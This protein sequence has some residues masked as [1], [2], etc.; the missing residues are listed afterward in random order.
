MNTPGYIVTGSGTINLFWEGKQYVVDKSHTNYDKVKDALR[1]KVYDNLEALVNVPKSVQNFGKKDGSTTLEVRDGTVFYMGEQVH[2]VV[3]DAILRFINDGFPADP[4]LRFLENLLQN[5]SKTS[6]DTLYNFLER[7]GLVITEDGCFLAYKKVD[8]DFKDYYSHTIDNSVGNVVR[9]VRNK[10]KDDPTVGCSDGLHVGSLNYA[11]VE[12]RPGEGIVLLTKVNPKDVVSVPHDCNCQKIR[13]CEYT[14]LEQM[15][16]F[17][18]VRQETVLSPVP[19]AQPTDTCPECGSDTC[20]GTCGD[21][22]YDEDEDDEDDNKLVCD[23]CGEE[24][25]YCRCE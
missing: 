8:T 18:V 22:D 12:Y 5:P 17:T 14:V 15:D 2:N 21:D 19:P 13:T 24:Y 6:V 16:N 25:H 10:V 7:H 1:T 3:V 11:S 20:V 4:M 9:M 23:V